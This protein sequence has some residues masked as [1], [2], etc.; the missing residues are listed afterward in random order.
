MGWDMIVDAS[1]VP[2]ATS[3]ATQGKWFIDADPSH[4]IYNYTSLMLL[5]RDRR[6]DA[7]TGSEKKLQT[8]GVL[9]RCSGSFT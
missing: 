6:T 5:G 9:Q 2:R 4:A 3:E 1:M 8:V 7:K